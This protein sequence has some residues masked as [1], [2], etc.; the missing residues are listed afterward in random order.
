MKTCFHS[1]SNNV[2]LLF[3]KGTSYKGT[4]VDK[5]FILDFLWRF[6]ESHK[7]VVGTSTQSFTCHHTGIYGQKFYVNPKIIP[8]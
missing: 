3:P 6:Y 8:H 4:I 2:S 1:N 5:S 7:N